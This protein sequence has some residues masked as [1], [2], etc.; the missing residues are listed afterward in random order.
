MLKTLFAATLLFAL[1]PAPR[2]AHAAPDVVDSGARI[3]THRLPA[4]EGLHGPLFHDFR[5]YGP[6][7]SDFR[8]FGPPLPASVPDPIGPTADELVDTSHLLPGQLTP[9]IWPT[10]GVGEAL[11]GPPTPADEPEQRY[12]GPPLPVDV[13]MPFGPPVP[14]SEIPTAYGFVW[15]V[16]DEDSYQ[17]PDEKGNPGFRVVQGFIPGVRRGG[18]HMGVDLSN[19][20]SGSVVR[21]IADGIVALVS[22]RSKGDPRHT[23]WG[24]MIVLAHKLPGGEVVYSLLAHLKDRSIRVRPGDRVTA[25]QPIAEVGSTGRSEGPH[26][27]LEM[28]KYLNW[29]ALDLL[30]EGWQHVGFMNPLGFLATHLVRFP[31]LP[32]NHWAYPYAM[33]LVRMGVLSAGPSFVPEQPVTL[34]EFAD[35]LS[36][37]FGSDAPHLPAHPGDGPVSLASAISYLQDALLPAQASAGADQRNRRILVKSL[38]RATGRP[39]TD[40]EHPLTR[41][42]AAV[43][44]KAAL[45][46]DNREPASTA[47]APAGAKK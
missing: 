8:Y 21:S 35:M 42:E 18:R 27:H 14:P 4:P 45:G 15:P 26:L 12:A 33:P 37:A 9:M 25:G 17:E 44:L 30:P 41:A 46:A 40:F 24:N 39:A 43:L 16:G 5:Y 19:R 6:L 36:R 47:Q 23:G 32:E 29:N 10:V 13:A 31:D 7:A 11:A 34:G 38:E 2:P 3:A 1:T 22:D 20:Q 28:R